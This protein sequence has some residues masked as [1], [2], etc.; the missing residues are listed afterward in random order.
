MRRTL[1]F[2][3]ILVTLAFWSMSLWTLSGRLSGEELLWAAAPSLIGLV[4]MLI[5]YGTKRIFS[6]NDAVRRRFSTILALT[7]LVVV[8]CVYADAFF[9]KGML[10]E[11]GL[12]IWRLELYVDERLPL[13]LAF[14]GAV[15]HPVL[16][17]VAGVFLLIAPPP[18][19]DFFR[20]LRE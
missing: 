18:K 3:L 1:T 8:A 17:I 7:L 16:F 6:Y 15:C 9:L 20:N 14:A 12:E 11:R 5:L 13:T 2:A 19:N 4:L 10:F